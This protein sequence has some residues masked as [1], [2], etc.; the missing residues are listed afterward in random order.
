[1]LEQVIADTNVSAGALAIDGKKM[2]LVSRDGIINLWDLHQQVTKIQTPNRDEDLYAYIYKNHGRDT[3][4]RCM[5]ALTNRLGVFPSCEVGRFWVRIW[6]HEWDE[7]A[8]MVEERRYSAGCLALRMAVGWSPNCGRCHLVLLT[9]R[10]SQR[11]R[12]LR[13]SFGACDFVLT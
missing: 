13:K 6:P 5:Y 10:H 3:Q 8:S 4:S 9:K 7:Y 11:I 12:K 2:V 1:M